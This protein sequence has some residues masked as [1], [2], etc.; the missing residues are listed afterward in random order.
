MPRNLR[1]WGL[2]WLLIAALVTLPTALAV[3]SETEP[4]VSSQGV[5]VVEA[6]PDLAILSGRITTQSD[7]PEEAVT[8]ARKKLDILIR[9][10]KRAGISPRDL[11]AAQVM[12]N[13]LYHYPRNKPR[14]LTGYQA[15]ANFT[16]KLRSISRLSEFYGVLIKAGVTELNQ[17]QF[18]FSN[19]EELELKAIA[20][21]V[22]IAKRKAEAALEPLDQRVGK[23]L[24]LDVNT[25]WHQPP[26]F[27]GA[28]MAMM[29]ESADAAPQVNVGDQRI[30]ANVSVSFV[31]R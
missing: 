24:Q 4:R 8:S 12:V 1:S 6:Q 26:M 15:S 29:A 16:A 31:I 7:I 21:A 9:D 11:Q 22:K 5:G 19:R 27:K 18:D 10:L 17:T 23:V 28:R 20:K 2:W 3:A 14:Q 30:E 25:R 13:P